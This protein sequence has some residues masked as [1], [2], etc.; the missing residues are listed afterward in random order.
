MHGLETAS[1]VA[2]NTSVEPFFV[3]SFIQQFTEV[4]VLTNASFLVLDREVSPKFVFGE[5]KYGRRS[6]P[7]KGVKCISEEIIEDDFKDCDGYRS[8]TPLSKEIGPACVPSSKSSTS[9]QLGIFQP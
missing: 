8:S 9:Q 1:K 4:N 5:K 7:E 3:I 2:M 6:K